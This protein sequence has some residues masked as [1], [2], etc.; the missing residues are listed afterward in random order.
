MLVRH[1]VTRDING[2]TDIRRFVVA[3]G[4]PMYTQ[5]DRVQSVDLQKEKDTYISDTIKDDLGNDLFLDGSIKSLSRIISEG[6]LP[7]EDKL[8]DISKLVFP[9]EIKGS[10]LYAPYAGL[11]ILTGTMV[12]QGGDQFNPNGVVT[13]AEFLDGLNAIHFGANSNVA[14]K[15]TLDKISDESDYFNE[16]Y[17]S[18]LWGMSSPFFNLYTRKE[19]LRPITRIELAY[20]TVICWS[21]FIR[22]FNTAY[23]GDYYLGIT[24]DWEAPKKALEVY[25]D[26]F[27]YQVVNYMKDN[28]SVS[29][30]IK[31]YKGD[32]SVTEFID[33]VLDGE[34]GIPMPM[35]MSLLELGK[36]GVFPFEDDRLD[37]LREVSRGEFSFFINKITE[38]T[39]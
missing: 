32:L 25:D 39:K 18:C 5:Y 16:G 3:N 34:L 11:S 33:K 22:K 37:P 30:N 36:L 24:F 15:K 19:F 27:D 1:V 35:F 14:R 6:I 20:I 8:T 4:V 23:G 31:D 17:Q 2:G 28:D 9:N 12:K 7:K 29:L 21:R 38:R 13:L 10:E 26:G